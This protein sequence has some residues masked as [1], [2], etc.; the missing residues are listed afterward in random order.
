MKFCRIFDFTKIQQ[1][2]FICYRHSLFQEGA[3]EDQAE[4]SAGLGYPHPIVYY[5]GIWTDSSSERELRNQ[6]QKNK[7]KKTFYYYFIIFFI[8][9]NKIIE[10]L[11]Q[12]PFSFSSKYTTITSSVRRFVPHNLKLQSDSEACTAAAVAAVS[13]R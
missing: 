2:I 5:R 8:L 6:F 10:I 1:K 11:G 12:R 3:K 9:K 13:Y 4:D 7:T